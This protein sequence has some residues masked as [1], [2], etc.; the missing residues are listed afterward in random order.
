MSQTAENAAVS[1]L[2]IGLNE[3]VSSGGRGSSR[4]DRI[5]MWSD[6]MYYYRGLVNEID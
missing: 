4:V 6:S 5:N 1:I 2:L 3:I